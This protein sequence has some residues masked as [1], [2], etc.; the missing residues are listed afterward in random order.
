MLP[1]EGRGKREVDRQIERET[2]QH[3]FLNYESSLFTVQESMILHGLHNF[4]IY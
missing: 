2:E 4:N 3:A 1:V